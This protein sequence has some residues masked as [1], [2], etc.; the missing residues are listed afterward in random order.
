MFSA[1]LPAYFQSFI[2]PEEIIQ[3][4]LKMIDVTLL[5]THG[6]GLKDIKYLEENHHFQGGNPPR[7][8]KRVVVL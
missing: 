4:L 7:P 3:N 2:G 8:G 1:L 5:E 6:E